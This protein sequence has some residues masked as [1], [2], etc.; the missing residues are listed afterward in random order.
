MASADKV[1]NEALA[2]PAGHRAGVAQA[3]L[4]SLDDGADEDAGAGGRAV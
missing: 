2:S 3:L 1:L 4:R